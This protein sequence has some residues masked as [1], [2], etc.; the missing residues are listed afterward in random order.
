MTATATRPPAA[1]PDGARPPAGGAPRRE[2]RPTLRL[3]AELSLW[4]VTAAAA[5]SFDRL[6]DE[7]SFLAPVLLA[8]VA[9]HAFAAF[10][11][12]RRV[13]VA[14][15]A[16]ASMVAMVLVLTWV[17]Y[18]FTT[19]AGLPGALTWDTFTA[20]LREAVTR[21]REDQAPVEPVRGFVAGSAVGFWIVAF[22][23]DWSAF[24]L[25]APLES[26]IP[27]GSLFVFASLLGADQSRTVTTVLFFLAA[28]GFLLLHRLARL[29]MSPSWVRGDSRSG[30]RAQL[31]VGGGITAVALVGVALVGPFL[32]GAT[33]APLLD[34]KDI[35]N[36]DDTRITVSPLV[37]IKQRL[38]DQ[39]ETEVF[40]VTSPVHAYWRLTALDEF[41]GRTW[42]SSKRF[43]KVDGDL[44]GATSAG[45]TQVTQQFSISNLAQIWLPAAFEPLS[46]TAEDRQVRWEPTTATLIVDRET[47]DGLE[48][49]VT[50]SVT[51]HA[52]DE[53]R[54]AGPVVP[55]DIADEFLALPRRLP[56][57]VQQLARDITAGA[58]T[59]YDRALALQNYFRDN[60]TYSVEVT[61]GQDI[62]AIEE[63]LFSDVQAGYCEQF[64]GSFAAMARSIGLPAR[65]A[66][67]SRWAT[68]EPERPDSYIVKG[69]HSHA[70]PEVYLDGFGWVLFEPTP[71]RGAANATYTGT[72][73]LQDSDVA[74]NG[75]TTTTTAPVVDPTA[76]S[77]PFEEFPAGGVVSE[78]L[79][80]EGLGGGGGSTPAVNTTGA[81]VVLA[82]IGLVAAYV[83][84][85][86][87]AR[88]LRRRRRRA[89]A[90]D[91]NARIDVAWRDATDALHLIGVH[92]AVGETPN[93]FAVRADN[94]SRAGTQM[95]ELAELT[96]SAR[97]APDAADDAAVQRAV[98]LAD[99]VSRAV[100][101]Q[102]TTGER[103]KA[104]LDPRPLLRRG[105]HAATHGNRTDEDTEDQQRTLVH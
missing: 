74:P 46:V 16:V 59:P 10:L 75:V 32:P 8:V 7:R 37:D 14:I 66:V 105:W 93:E 43:E 77:L 11:R 73:E 84:A 52:P 62:N 40:R 35:G 80:E 83:L 56:D 50:S 90:G 45:D 79:P 42:K 2:V 34:V 12:R 104:E 88:A 65:V 5:V 57:S 22:L 55:S 27:A 72:S 25:W 70:W 17:F 97:Y 82:I 78:G 6:F 69:R 38:V 89:R 47:S 67:D 86:P 1:P 100:R 64:A 98:V 13:P 51:D 61:G 33:A 4:V 91:G 58:G 41:D 68:R 36:D 19:R 15:A 31:A 30:V 103:I 29:E 99:G 28:V 39:R 102:T 26:T 92:Q 60:Y 21:F 20:D 81:R 71:G 23:A 87:T 95:R 3:P 63:F 49:S 44:P 94:R 18:F 48:Y 101:E 53:L 54:G 76:T 24:R 9:S 85:V 96:T